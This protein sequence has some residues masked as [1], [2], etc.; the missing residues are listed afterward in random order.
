MIV[1]NEWLLGKKKIES[2]FH[3]RNFNL[4]HGFFDQSHV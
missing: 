1:L 3:I 4:L 2:P